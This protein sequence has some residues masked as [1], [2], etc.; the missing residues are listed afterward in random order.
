MFRRSFKKP[1]QVKKS[2][3]Q[4]VQIFQYSEYDVEVF[5]EFKFETEWRCSKITSKTKLKFF[6]FFCFIEGERRGFVNNNIP[7]DSLI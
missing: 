5:Q 2:Q 6:F 7:N 4:N 1:P 3:H